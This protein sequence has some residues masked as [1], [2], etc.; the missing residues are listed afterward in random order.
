MTN[1]QKAIIVVCL[2]NLIRGHYHH[3]NGKSSSYWFGLN[4]L[5]WLILLVIGGFAP[6]W[7]NYAAKTFG[8]G[9]GVD[10]ALY[11]SVILLW[12]FILKVIQKQARTSEELTELVRAVAIKNA[13]GGQS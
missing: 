9:R 3:S 6:N 5:V 7:T 1:F 13:R 2:Y 10:L 12:T 8:I 4:T 11:V